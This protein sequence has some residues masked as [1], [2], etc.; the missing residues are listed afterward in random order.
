MDINWS[1]L[2]WQGRWDALGI[3]W[4]AILIDIASH[5][6]FGPLL[7]MVVV[8]A[9]WKGIARLG[10]YVARVFIHTHGPS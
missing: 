6:W 1:E 9:G 5:W 7:L 4:N 3:L 2:I 8:A 10:A